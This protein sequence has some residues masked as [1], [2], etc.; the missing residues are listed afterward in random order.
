MTDFNL[1]RSAGDTAHEVVIRTDKSGT[2]LV[3]SR[4]G[5]SALQTL[6]GHRLYREI[7]EMSGRP[8]EKCDRER[9]TLRSRTRLIRPRASQLDQKS[10]LVSYLSRMLKLFFKLMNSLYLL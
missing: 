9:L 2:A 6:R 3:T 5:F 7:V 8:E 1:H 10:R 4:Q